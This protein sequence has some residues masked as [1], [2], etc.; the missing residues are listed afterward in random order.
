[1]MDDLNEFSSAFY[2]NMDIYDN[3]IV[4]INVGVERQIPYSV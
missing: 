2:Y 1:M 4:K 3:V